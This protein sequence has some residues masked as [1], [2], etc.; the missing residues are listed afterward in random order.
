VSFDEGV[1]DNSLTDISSKCNLSLLGNF[2]FAINM[3]EG[4]QLYLLLNLTSNST[5]R[6][7]FM[8]HRIVVNSQS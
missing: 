4:F 1:F 6:H 2:H 8:I 7:E 5:A 3:L